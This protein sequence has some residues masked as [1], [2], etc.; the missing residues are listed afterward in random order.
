M[1]RRKRD[2]KEIGNAPTSAYVKRTA[3]ES[4]DPH[5]FYCETVYALGRRTQGRSSI[6]G[7]R[8]LFLRVRR[9]VAKNGRR[10]RRH[11][12]RVVH[13][14]TPYFRELFVV[15]TDG[16]RAP[17]LAQG[18]SMT[19]IKRDGLSVAYEMTRAI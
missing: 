16:Q 14:H 11:R 9:T 19:K 3:Q 18:R 17:R 15:P 8:K 1:G 12:G 10:R 7:V 4:F 13:I 2:N 6:R 5:G